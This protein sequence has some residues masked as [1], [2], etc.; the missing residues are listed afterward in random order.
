MHS[1]RAIS[2][3]KARFRALFAIKKGE[4]MQI[5]TEGERPADGKSLKRE[6][7]PS[8]T[9]LTKGWSLIWKQPFLSA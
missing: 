6:M 7:A 8:Q 2:I 9:A 5:K 1:H 3:S 4:L